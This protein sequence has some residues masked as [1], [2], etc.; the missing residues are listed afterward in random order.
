MCYIINIL[1]YF[2][3]DVI[4]FSFFNI[5]IFALQS[6]VLDLSLYLKDGNYLEKP[7]ENKK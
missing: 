3:D 1:L 7:P 5:F 2:N 4:F 6:S